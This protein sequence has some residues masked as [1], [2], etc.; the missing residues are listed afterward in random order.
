M[1]DFTQPY[2]QSSLEMVVPLQATNVIKFWIFLA[3]FSWGLW[4]TI[5]VTFVATIVSLFIVE[6]WSRDRETTGHNWRDDLS[7]SFW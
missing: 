2:L 6:H 7:N 1:V 5:A 3:P 4:G